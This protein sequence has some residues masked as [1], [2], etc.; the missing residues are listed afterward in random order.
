MEWGNILHKK[1]LFM[2]SAYSSREEC[3]YSYCQTI[4][5]GVEYIRFGD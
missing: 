3:L 2:E 1:V 5:S 4:Y